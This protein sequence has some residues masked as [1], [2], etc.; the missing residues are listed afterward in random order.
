MRILGLSLTRSN[1]AALVVTLVSA[2]LL[3]AITWSP[4]ASTQASYSGV[5]MSVP[6]PP[7]D[8]PRDPDGAP[9]RPV[10]SSLQPAPEYGLR[11]DASPP[12]VE[13]PTPTP[14]ESDLNWRR[15]RSEK[16]PS[17]ELECQYKHNDEL[18]YC[19][20]FLTAEQL[21]LEGKPAPRPGCRKELYLALQACMRGCGIQIPD[22]RV[23]PAPRRAN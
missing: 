3:V 19:G 9:A 13:I 1:S 4:D 21:A 12:A 7:R 18:P 17:C 22:L 11:A 15:D 23:V 14:K 8:V 10:G 5:D 6:M 20:G 2:F 16:A